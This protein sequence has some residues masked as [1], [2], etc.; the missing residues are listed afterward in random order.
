MFRKLLDKYIQDPVLFAACAFFALFFLGMV[1]HQL[2]P[3]YNALVE[4]TGGGWAAVVEMYHNA[5]LAIIL[6]FQ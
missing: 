2:T 4:D 3:Y 5:E 6:M 1:K